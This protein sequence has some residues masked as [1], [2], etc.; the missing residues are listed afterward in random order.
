MKFLYGTSNFSKH[1]KQ[2]FKGLNIDLYGL[3]DLG[4][5]IKVDESGS[6]PME[7]ARIKALAYYKVSKIPTFSCDSGLYIEGLSKDKQPG[8]FVRRK[9][10]KNLNDEEYIKYYTEGVNHV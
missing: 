10:C 8:V 7:N 3:S 9:D 2:M 4:I 6:T 1:M 5:N